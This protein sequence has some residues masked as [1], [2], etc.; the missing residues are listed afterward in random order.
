MCLITGRFTIIMLYIV[1]VSG[2]SILLIKRRILLL[3]NGEGISCIKLVACNV[4]LGLNI[5]NRKNTII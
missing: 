3:C 1:F 5:P 4:M 2:M